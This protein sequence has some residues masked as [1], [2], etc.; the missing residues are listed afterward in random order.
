MN[1][2][3]NR[4]MSVRFGVQELQVGCRVLAVL[5][6]FWGMA[7]PGMSADD[8]SRGDQQ[9]LSPADRVFFEKMARRIEPDLKGK[10][11]RLSQYIEFYKQQLGNDDR[12]F[13]VEVTAT[14]GSGNARSIILN[15]HV[16]FAEHRL[17]VAAML[18][19][20]GFR[21]LRN[22]IALLPDP[23]LGDR[24]F[25][26]MSVSG[27][28]SRERPSEDADVVTQCLLGEP[29]W[30]LRKSGDYYLCHAEDGYLGY[31]AASDIRVVN[32]HEFTRYCG[33]PHVSVR[34]THQAGKRVLPTGARLK[35]VGE[36]ENGFRVQLPDGYVIDI[37]SGACVI[38]ENASRKVEQIID[39]GKRF[40]GTAYLWGG[41]TQ[42]GIDC[43]GLVQVAFKA[44]GLHLP[45]DSNQQVFL[46]NLTGTRWHTESMRRGDTMYFLGKRGR[47]RHTAVYLGDSL[48]LHAVSPSVTVGSLDPDHSAY[49]A[50]LHASF[51]LAKRLIE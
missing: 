44:A 21:I 11:S 43:S 36:I 9:I 5:A 24:R 2:A 3:F 16:E 23:L 38:N 37:E 48:F 49:D 8:A 25:G 51:A 28:M 35:L 31:V 10:S 29:L 22:E 18:Q 41:K 20:L 4:P 32:E 1:S 7:T 39:V 27:S 40:M 47:I 14:L 6:A 26:L 42:S 33:G 13:A 45:R 46:G 15:G 50:N 19:I 34:A 30:L 17:S 12:L